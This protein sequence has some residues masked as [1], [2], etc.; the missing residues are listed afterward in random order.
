MEGVSCPPKT[1]P[2]VPL[3]SESVR[4]LIENDPIGIRSPRQVTAASLRLVSELAATL[5]ALDSSSSCRSPMG[6]AHDRRSQRNA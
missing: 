6:H 3:S 2:S 1:A 4:F 5:A